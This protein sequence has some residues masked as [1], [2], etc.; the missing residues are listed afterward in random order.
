LTF[1]RLHY[2]SISS[3]LVN[4][5]VQFV[6]FFFF[7]YYLVLMILPYFV[8]AEHRENSL[9]QLS[10]SGNSCEY[11]YFYQIYNNI[12]LNVVLYIID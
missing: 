3:K 11:V 7:S 5:G 2:I 6:Y 1:I 8:Y 4:L 12:K 10:S 9:G